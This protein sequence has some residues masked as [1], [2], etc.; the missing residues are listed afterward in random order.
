MNSLEIRRKQAKKKWEA[1]M[2]SP[3]PTI[4]I[5]TASCG[6]AAG[7]L[8]VLETVHS[9]LMEN[10]VKANLVQVG[11]IGPCY[12]EPLMD[13]QMPGMPRLSYGNVT[14]EKARKIIQAHI[15]ERKPMFKIALGHFGDDEFTQSSGVPRFFDHPMLKRQVRIILRNC[16]LIDP[17]NLDHYL[18]RDG[19]VGFTNALK[20][21]PEQCI[22][23]VK[24]A[25]LRGRGGAGFPT[26]KKWEICRNSPGKAKYVIC[27]ADE[28][29]PGAFMNRSLIEGDP[30]AIVEGMLIAA[31]AIGASQGFVYVRAEYPLAVIRLAK[32]LE[33]A[34]QL[35]LLGRNILGSN[36]DFDIIIKEGAGAFVCGEETA[37]IASIEGRRGMP[38]SR[39][40]YP[41]ESGLYGEPTNINNTE[42]YG[43]LPNIFRYGS[44][45]YQQ[46]GIPG[47]SGTKTFSL[48]G[49]LR[50]TGLIEVPL[51][52][53]LR[54]IIY[55]VG[56]GPLKKFKGVQTGGPSGGCLSEKHL[57]TPIDFESLRA[58]GSIMG[59]G[60]LII[61]DESSCVVDVARYFLNFSMREICG[62]CST[63]RIG[64]RL[65]TEILELI[66]K[67]EGTQ[68]DLDLLYSVAETVVS[69]SLCGGGQT[70]PNPVLTTLRH[71]EE[72]YRSHIVDKFCPAGVCT[73][74][75]EYII[76]PEKCNGCSA[77]VRVCPTGAIYGE[78]KDVH[79]L[80]TNLCIKCR[81]CYETCRFDAIRSVPITNLTEE[82]VLM[83]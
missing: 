69:G 34:R 22:E 64:T 75:F 48:V 71:F 39:P 1:L 60:G 38:R 30:H 27:N 7:A 5:G 35:G 16:G 80:D 50:R 55:D 52:M 42:T 59:S 81:A 62:R 74:L 14:P 20:L 12:L 19:Y 41:A 61:L 21:T 83:E 78:K 15:L 17:E 49:R 77:C 3:F 63:C 37:M 66:T 26:Y 56:G 13:I 9:F 47:N 6:R 44:H 36:F 45:W 57:D 43:T 72:E 29:D 28:G 32:A 23:I 2:H 46:F 54:E 76:E 11:C 10:K 24:E 70:V 53:T 8:E 40:P 33:E 25:G 4:F 82:P 68:E 79:V 18:A 73:S 67:G 51:G 31:Y 58:N 65:L